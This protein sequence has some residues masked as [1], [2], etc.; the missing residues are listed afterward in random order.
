M[1]DDDLANLCFDL[2][3][4]YSDLPGDTRSAK[5]RELILHFERRGML[6]EL[7]QAIARQRP[8]IF[9]E[10]GWINILRSPRGQGRTVIVVFLAIIIIGLIVTSIFG[11]AIVDLMG[12]TPGRPTPTAIVVVAA[13]TATPSPTMTPSATPTDTTTPTQTASPTPTPTSSATPTATSTPTKT[14]SPTPDGIWIDDFEDGVEG[15][16]AADWDPRVDRAFGVFPSLD[17]AVGERALKCDFDFT[18]F[19]GPDPRA[20][21]FTG[22]LPIQDWVGHNF[23]QFQAKSLVDL[24]TNIRVYLALA[25]GPLSCFNELGEFQLFESEENLQSE[26]QTFTFNLDQPL[27]R[28]CEDDSEYDETLIGKEEVVRLHLI[29]TAERE[30]SGG[31]LIDEIWL[32]RS[33]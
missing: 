13:H 28:T 32:L 11:P 1:S 16:Y 18:G 7:E 21:C 33:Q 19:V 30:P 3:I 12:L 4:V 9:D 15:W 14:P 27:Y 24:S 20:I 17:A 29:F 23:L 8:G 25:T 10:N 6:D 31:V 22:D 26:Y 5:I 2:G